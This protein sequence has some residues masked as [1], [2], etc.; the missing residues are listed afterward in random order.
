VT[1][2]IFSGHA[3]VTVGWI[4][5]CRLVES[6]QKEKSMKQKRFFVGA[7]ALFLAACN[8]PTEPLGGT[9]SGSVRL[10]VGNTGLV[11]PMLQT[12]P[13]P[14]T[15]SR[16][17]V[18]T[19]EV[20]V[21]FK[22]N[23]AVQRFE[24]LSANGLELQQVRGLALKNTAL[25]RSKTSASTET[26]ARVLASRLDVEWAQP[27]YL[28][29]SLATPNDPA[30]SAQWHYPVL[31]LP[32]AW[33]TEKG[34][35]NPVTVAVLDTGV[36]VN[37]PDLQG[38]LL[39][40]YDFITNPQ[41]AG[42]GDGRDN[43]ADD[44]G[45]NPNGQSSYHGSH[46]AGTIAAS[47]N[48][49]AGVAGVSWGAKILPVR[50]LGIQGG[51]VADIA[52]AIVWASGGTVQGTPNNPN[53]AQVI[54]MSLG[55]ARPC[56]DT[57]AY[58]E[59]INAAV[60]RGSIVVVAAGNSNQDASGFTPA[61]CSSVLTVGATQ[62]SNQRARYSNFGNR[63]DVM[64]PGGDVNADLNNDTY[65]DGVLSLGKNDQNGEFV[66]IFENGTSMAAPHV[67]GVVA[68]M[69]AKD[70]SLN[71]ARALDVLKRTARPL[72]TEA[73]TGQGPTQTPSDCGAG[74]IDAAAALQALS[75]GN[76]PN[77]QPDFS[78]RLDPNSL[79]LK[80]GASA[81]V[82]L[83]VSGSN[84]FTGA[85]QFTLSGQPN[86]VTGSFNNNVLTLNTATSATAGN[87]ALNIQGQ[88]GNLTRSASLT[89]TLT[90]G[91][92]SRP[93]VTGTFVLA[94]YYLGNDCDSV[95]SRITQVVGAGGVASYGFT[96]LS[97]G[98]YL[99]IAWK[100][101]DN[102]QDINNGDF[103]GV[104]NKNGNL[105]L[106]QPSARNLEIPMELVV[107]TNAN[108]AAQRIRAFSR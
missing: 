18:A 6:H 93:S 72:S 56:T 12:P 11:V 19:G 85:V 31:N 30:Y 60:G 47:S 101:S 59:A 62:F 52:D 88:S 42:D 73:C 5:C 3:S 22:S 95:K 4:A 53:P 39:P 66:Y 28:F 75:G 78:F 14:V 96:E 46:V 33:D 15:S 74:L 65:P 94:C 58:Q 83:T 104:Y 80:A 103:V 105:A 79:S 43:N 77:P 51:S 97:L 70:P 100:D 36:L 45:D 27:N 10:N 98:D 89:L 37:H 54:N 67:A 57:P 20:I 64:A 84:G 55:G 108:H 69:K 81:T 91:A 23:L 99:M 76:N 17:V 24:R 50:V 25:Y 40:G 41:N 13:R 90:T 35:S 87:Y 86:G 63:I 26:L 38:K 9:L 107:D 8:T 68:L 82:N 29:Q 102:N 1:A 16:V 2:L 21:K 71:L 106:V 49:G 7:L 92:V 44:P 32:K 48:N 34:N 61:S